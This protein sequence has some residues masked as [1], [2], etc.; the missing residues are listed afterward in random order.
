VTTTSRAASRETSRPV[1]PPADR[2]LPARQQRIRISEKSWG[3]PFIPG[4]P[5][6]WPTAPVPPGLRA[7][8]NPYAYWRPP[9][10]D[11][12]HESAVSARRCRVKP[13]PRVSLLNAVEY[14]PE[15]RCSWRQ[16]RAHFKPS[17]P[18]CAP[19]A[20]HA[21][22]SPSATALYNAFATDTSSVRFSRP[23][24]PVL[25][26]SCRTFPM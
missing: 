11:R 5:P 1:V 10:G 15:S 13:H 4:A 8:S 3:S 18:Q 23:R 26:C 6:L 9:V 16:A 2:G 14:Y 12:G 21:T 20:I 17:N 25:A 19:H 22:I 24:R 7:S